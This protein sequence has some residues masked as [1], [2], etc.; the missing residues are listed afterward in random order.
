MAN[1][2]EAAKSSGAKNFVEDVAVV[3]ERQLVRIEAVHRGF[4]YQHIYG[5]ICLLLAGANGVDRVIVERDEDVE[6]VLPHRRVYIQIKTRIGSLSFGDIEGALQRF[7]EIRR[8]HGKGA[9]DG[10][11]GFLIVSNAA[12]SGPLLKKFASDD[13]PKDVQLHWPD[14]PAPTDSFLPVPPKSIGDAISTCSTLAGKL[15]FALLKPETLTWKLASIV[16]FASAGSPPRQDH[17]FSREELTALFEQLVVQM[18]ELPAPPPVYRAQIDEP[19]LL[20]DQCVRIVSGLSGAGKTAWVAE[21]A[22]HAP[23]PVTYIDVVDTPGPAL[24]SAVTREVAARIFGRSGGKLGEILLPGASGLDT[25]GALSVKLGEEGVYVH[26]VIDNAHR[27]PASDIEAIVA[28]APH[29]RFL[30]LAQP[31]AEVIAMEARLAVTAE[32]LHG[33]DEDTIAA[34]LHDA[35]CQAD[36]GDCQRL[37]RLTGGLPFYVLNAATVA[38]REYGGSVRAFCADVEA[39]THVVETAQ[40]IILKRAFEGLSAEARETIAILSLADVALSRDEAMKLLQGASDIDARAGAARLRA[41][42]ATGALELFGNS[43]LKVHDAVRMLGLA[44]LAGR[45]GA[46]ESKAKAALRE[47]II[48][49]IRKDWSIAKLGLLIRLFGQ[50]GDARILVGFATDELFHEMGVWPEIEPFLVDI[51]ASAEADPETRLWA[52]DGLVFNDLR[53]GAFEPARGRI[54]EMQVLVEANGLGEDEWLA[55]GMKR[56]LLRSMLGDAKGVNE[57]LGMV[58]RR[59]SAKAEHMRVFRYNRALAL[60]KLGDNTTAVAAASEL[61]EEYY[62]ELGITPGDVM[63]RSAGELRRQLPT[64]RDITNTLKHL[65]DTLDLLAQ[66]A[67]RMSQRSVLA[68][69]H[70]MKFYEL[71]HAFDSLVRVGLDLVDELVWVN[72][73]IGARQVLERSIFPIMQGVGLASRVIET[74]A[75]YAVVLAYC[76]DHQAAADEVARLRPFE[77]AMAPGH[78]EAFQN[79]KRLIENVRRFGGPRQQEVNIPASLQALFDQRRGAP[80]VVEPRRKVGRNERCPCGSGKKYKQ[81]HG[82]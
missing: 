75:L 79:Q 40:E 15:P 41:L 28:R 72:D 33:W 68:R 36:F 4:L 1:D 13:W 22:L 14:G 10:D 61:I 45:G 26:V 48:V 7:D 30:L 27:V 39:Q 65:A 11:A 35:G 43:A 9:R 57:M 60:F 82:R 29:L 70:A 63:G 37:S 23:L 67:G 32:T 46:A 16:M 59:I 6:I 58:E 71:A 19:A 38:A 17:S 44:D 78:R 81:C 3:D 62:G 66:A 74:R 76:G 53:E 54:D 73:F 49:S 52:L 8:E 64:V 18:Q 12:P 5:A 24:A 69:I 34:A 20:G 80:R 2:S 31:G 21:A 42:P 51:A 77:E 56:M 25:L 50:L 55:W 47:V